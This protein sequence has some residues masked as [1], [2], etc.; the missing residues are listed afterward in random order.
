MT[1]RQMNTTDK[2]PNINSS[3]GGFYD[4]ALEPR[5]LDWPDI[6]HAAIIEL[7]YLK[8]GEPG[9]MILP[10]DGTENLRFVNNPAS[11]GTVSLHRLVLVFRGGV[12]LMAEEV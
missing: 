5:L 8:P 1:K 4:I 12:C 3:G 10:I 2:N 11:G 9:K 7:K 6:A